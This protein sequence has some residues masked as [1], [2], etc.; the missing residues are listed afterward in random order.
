[1]YMSTRFSMGGLYVLYYKP[2]K[3]LTILNKCFI[4][5][6]L[7]ARGK[8][9]LDM[10]II[11]KMTRGEEVFWI[12]PDLNNELS[13]EITTA[14]VDD[15][16][17]RLARFAP[18]IKK[19]FPDTAQ[20]EGIIESPLAD[21]P[22]MREFLA[23][24]AA[25]KL[26][27]GKAKPVIQGRLMLKCD[28]LLPVSGSVKA[29]GGVYEVLCVAE[30]LALENGMLKSGDDYSVLLEERF[31]KLFS[32]YSLAV[33]STGNL[34]LSIGITG[35]RLGFH[36]TV[37]MSADAKEWKKNLLRARG[38]KV[39]EYA[40]DYQ[41]AVKEGRE[42]AQKD[43]FCHFVDDENSKTLFLGY[44][45]AAQRLCAQLLDKGICVDRDHPLFVYLPCGVGGAPGGVA[46]GLKQIYGADAH[47]FFAEPVNAPCM[48]LGVMTGKHDQICVQDIGLSGRTAADGL[49]VGRP[50]KLVGRLAGNLIDGFFT[51]SEPQ[52]AR[53]ADA[54]YSR[55]NIFIEPSA[56]AGI[57][58]YYLT[59]IHSE[60]ASR[61]SADTLKNATHI[62]W[63]TGGRELMMSAKGI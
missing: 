14:D 25:L 17:A 48:L 42:L 7:P 22:A 37:H 41:K 2:I 62:V 20:N 15:A 47:C 40:G 13:P 61:F 43:P 8:T 1:M 19:A 32:L 6:V 9:E 33:G 49:A 3:I 56:A 28:N 31:R 10:K 54:L 29:R 5:S 39:V 26:F 23:E 55:E 24:D 51:L 38:A 27:E 18:Y 63:A 58:G 21:I 45:V 30:R 34:G 52:F 46:Y 50:S 12:N 35:A 59:Q 16:A 57:P 60:Y 4:L 36:V 53:L 44:A 11:E